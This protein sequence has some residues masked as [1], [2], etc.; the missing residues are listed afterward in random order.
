MESKDIIT[1]FGPIL[2]CLS[3]LPFVLEEAN[4]VLSQAYPSLYELFIAWRIEVVE[5]Q[6]KGLSFSV[7]TSC[8]ERL[9]FVFMFTLM[10]ISISCPISCVFVNICIHGCNYVYT[11]LN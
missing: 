3:L 2:V 5:A 9:S 4:S 1:K 7:S 10:E 8:R 6:V 11:C